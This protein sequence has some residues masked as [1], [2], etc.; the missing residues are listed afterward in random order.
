MPCRQR[1]HWQ[2]KLLL[3]KRAWI[4]SNSHQGTLSTWQFEVII[5]NINLD[6][7][8]I[9]FSPALD[10]LP[11]YLISN[12]LHQLAEDEKPFFFT[13]LHLQRHSISKKIYGFQLLRWHPTC[14]LLSL[15]LPKHL[16]CASSSL[17]FLLF[18]GTK[19]L[20]IFIWFLLVLALGH[21]LTRTLIGHQLLSTPLQP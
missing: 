1:W 19:T 20:Q 8:V 12:M 15:F 7:C 14:A 18:L 3:P 17:T 11:P 16:S 2:S 9:S 4:S 6:L 5:C 10:P 13:L 21:F